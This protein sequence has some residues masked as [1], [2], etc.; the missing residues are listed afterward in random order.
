MILI[1]LYNVPP[2]FSPFVIY[3]KSE[4]IHTIISIFS[5]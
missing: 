1:I 3:E 5:S 4:V 2:I